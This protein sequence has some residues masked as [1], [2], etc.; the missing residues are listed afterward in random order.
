MH[1][2]D[3]ESTSLSFFL[4]FLSKS[5]LFFG[6]NGFGS[7]LVLKPV[8]EPNPILKTTFLGINLQIKPCEKM[9]LKLTNRT[10]Y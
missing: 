2:L 3:F 5:S 8:F 4:S 10:N 9:D 7:K 6:Q 1:G